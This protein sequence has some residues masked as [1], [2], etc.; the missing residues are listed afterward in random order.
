MFTVLIFIVLNNMKLN[1][2][3]PV[4]DR[5]NVHNKSNIFSKNKIVSIG[6]RRSTIKQNTFVKFIHGLE[7]IS[8]IFV[9][10][11]VLSMLGCNIFIVI[12]LQLVFIFFYN[13]QHIQFILSE[14]KGGVQTRK[15]P[16]ITSLLKPLYYT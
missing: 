9:T 4:C 11:I 14:V 2:G 16:L 8:Y 6:S 7:I 5:H 13:G 15:T 10:N 1:S 12:P 3:R